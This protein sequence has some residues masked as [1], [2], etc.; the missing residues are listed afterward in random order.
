MIDDDN[1]LDPVTL[2]QPI[3]DWQPTHSPDGAL[4]GLG[5]RS[6][7]AGA[8]GVLAF[9]ALALGALAIGAVAIGR[10]G[11]GRARVGTLEIDHLIVGRVSM[12]KRR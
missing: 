10:L 3:V 12:L 1:P 9:G 7:S 11:V 6:L 5:P 8:A 2:P 4:A